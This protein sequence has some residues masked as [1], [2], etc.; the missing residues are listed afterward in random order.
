[1]GTINAGDKVVTTDTEHNSVL[2]P[3]YY[4]QKEKNIVILK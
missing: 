1:M 3:L 2:R 4:L